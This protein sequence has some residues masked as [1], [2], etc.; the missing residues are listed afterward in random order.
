MKRLTALSLAMVLSPTAIAQE[1][2]DLRVL[3]ETIDG[4]APSDMMKHYLLR[5]VREAQERWTEAYEQRKTSEQIEAYQ[6]EVRERFREALGEMPAHTKLNAQIAGVI[7][8]EG[9]R[10]EKIVF[11]SQAQHFVTGA[12]F[13]PDV[14]HFPGPRPAV[15]VPCG[16]THNGKAHDAYQR[17]A[18]LLAI[19]GIIAFSIDPFDQGERMQWLNDDGSPRTWGTL[20]H[21][22]VGVGS[23]LLGRN[24]ATYEVWDCMRAIEYLQQRPEVDPDRIGCMGNSGGGTQTSHLLVYDDRVKAASPS[25]YITSFTRLIETIGVQDA[26]QNV[27]GQLAFGMDHADFI[28]SRAPTPVLICA[29]TG[30]FFDIQ[31]T[32]NTYRLAKRLYTRLGFAERV[33]LIED[34]LGHNYD[35]NARQA[36]V[37]WMVRWLDGRNE[38]IVEGD[39]QTLTDD[40]LRCTPEGQTMLIDG[41]R[42][43][44]DINRAYGAELAERRIELWASRT[45]DEMLSRVRSIAGIRPLDELP[46]VAV[47]ETGAIDRD[48]HRITKFIFHPEPGIRLPALLYEPSESSGTAALYLHGSGMATAAGT[49]GPIEQMVA[50][51]LTVLGV[52]VRGVGETAQTGQRYFQPYFGPDGQDFYTAYLLGRSFVGMRAEDILMCARWLFEEH[53]AV[54]LTATEHLCVPALHAAALEPQLFESIDLV[55]PP[56]TWSETVEAGWTTGTL[57]NTVHGALH[58][59]DLPDLQRVVDTAH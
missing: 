38:P 3:P 34:D 10:V 33:D 7:E 24:A 37:R 42:S 13:I 14:E 57:M 56:P 27:F 15:L 36:A 9:Y 21:T 43:L 26:E 8:R 17:A 45:T 35:R 40:E 6:S 18:A 29:A 30:D 28:M 48:S 54:R 59:Y 23:I 41:A 51:G 46:A 55:E 47:E 11:E 25:C 52:D 1:A 44:Y 12:M 53:G 58:V 20:G 49:A 31:G 22:M 32:W 39:I 5:H 16:H 2:P 50:Q 4:V 19:N